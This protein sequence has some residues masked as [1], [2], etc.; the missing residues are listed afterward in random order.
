MTVASIFAHSCLRHNCVFRAISLSKRVIGRPVEEGFSLAT[1]AFLQK[2]GC[3]HT[4]EL[5]PQVK[6]AD[7]LQALKS[8]QDLLD[9]KSQNR[10]MSEV[11]CLVLRHFNTMQHGS[12]R[13]W[14]MLRTQARYMNPHFQISPS[15]KPCLQSAF[16]CVGSG[17]ASVEQCPPALI[18]IW[19]NQNAEPLQ[20]LTTVVP[21]RTHEQV[22]MQLLG[23]SRESKIHV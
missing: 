3:Q 8:R 1:P 18:A 14:S 23:N 5:R 22:E 9:Q 11:C 15:C 4:R 6:R 17:R 12:I 2:Q 10:Q 16:S 21:I 13:L 20:G 19:G 7:L